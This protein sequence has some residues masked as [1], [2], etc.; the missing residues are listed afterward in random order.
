MDDK[1]V[2]CFEAIKMFEE[3]NE[4]GLTSIHV[5]EWDENT[6]INYAP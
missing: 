4:G 3:T 2:I 5:Y 1:Q 6:T